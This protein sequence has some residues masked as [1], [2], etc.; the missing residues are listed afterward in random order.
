MKTKQ[1]G[2]SNLFASAIGLGCMGMSE[3]YGKCDETEA[4][5]TLLRA[6]DLGINFF[7]TADMYGY[8]ENEK[9]VG[10]IL[11]PH[12]DKIIIATKFGFVRDLNNP[13]ARI[14]NGHPDYVKIACEA[15]LA[16][17]GIDTIDLYYLHRVDAQVPIEETVGAMADLVHA[18]K[19]RYLGLS[20]A[21][22]QTIKRAL[23]IHPITAIQSEYSLWHRD[24][25]DEIIPL[26][27]QLEIAMVP[28][29]PLGRGF[30]THTITNAEHLAADDFRKTLPRFTGAN[31][32]K[33]LALVNKLTKIATSKNC[34]SAQLALA[35]VLAKSPSITPIPGTRREKYL[36]ENIAACEILL[37]PAEIA[38]LD[39]LF[40]K[41]AVH[42]DRY[43]PQ[44]MQLVNL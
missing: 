6:V 39:K 31:G 32:E 3:Y 25:E 38:E 27:E 42:G 29:S 9:L 43:S 20:E 23:K 8:G 19:V 44:G 15:S 34:T 11:K 7:D 40:A 13:Q 28:Y 30:L 22:A 16:R 2:K 21:S 33:N 37:N 10:K 1:L 4:A 41:S 12:R 24:P 17:L 14:I 5:G 35:W 26:C 18:G 36:Q